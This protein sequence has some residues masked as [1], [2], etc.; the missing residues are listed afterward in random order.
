MILK[1]NTRLALGCQRR[2]PEPILFYHQLPEGVAIINSSG[3]FC[4]S[5]YEGLRSHNA[6]DGK[7]FMNFLHPSQNESES[8]AIENRRSRSANGQV[9]K[10]ISQPRA[11]QCQRRTSRST[12]LTNG[13]FSQI[14]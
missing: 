11:H 1:R 5:L 10:V 13:R 6:A 9:G 4:S 8:S 3:L 14:V 12:A 2:S 7:T